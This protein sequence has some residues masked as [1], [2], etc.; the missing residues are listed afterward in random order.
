[1]SQ[2]VCAY[3]FVCVSV[4]VFYVCVLLIPREIRDSITT[5]NGCELHFRLNF[6]LSNINS[7]FDID[8]HN[9]SEKVDS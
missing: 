8:Q 2:I 7:T 5:G 6:D 4:H 9:S 3:L 1:M